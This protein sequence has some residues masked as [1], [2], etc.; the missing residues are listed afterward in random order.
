MSKF[1]RLMLLLGLLS[2]A[3]VVVI[4]YLGATDYF[5]DKAAPS[6]FAWILLFI[7]IGTTVL[8]A[9]SVVVS[10]ISKRREARHG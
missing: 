4:S 8:G 1:A 10:M 3:G 2:F 7:S 9:V 5:V 6:G